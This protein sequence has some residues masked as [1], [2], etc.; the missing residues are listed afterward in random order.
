MCKKW[1]ML[2]VDYGNVVARTST[3][4][5]IS[6]AVSATYVVETD[7]LFILN[8]VDHLFTII[9]LLIFLVFRFYSWRLKSVVEAG[10]LK[11]RC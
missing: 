9:G 6:I 3:S 2:S 5:T 10:I 4:L 1:L 8:L 7:V 11:V